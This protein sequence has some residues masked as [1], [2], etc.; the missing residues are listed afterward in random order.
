M[1]INTL[2]DGKCIGF[3]DVCKTPVPNGIL[4]IPYTNT[5]ECCLAES[6]S[7]SS[8]VFVNGMNA[9][10]LNTTITQSNGNEAG[11][12]GGVASGRFRGPACFLSGSNA[13][14]IEG[15][16]AVA[17]GSSTGQNGSTPNC[18]GNCITPSQEKVLL[19]R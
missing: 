15:A 3:P 13:V 5:A 1:F 11:T 16:P 19:R 7:F 2:E 9:L 10:H 17:L 8:K 6:G 18:T 12:A 4:P 14:L